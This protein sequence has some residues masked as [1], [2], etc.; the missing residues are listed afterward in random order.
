MKR[1]MLIDLDAVKDKGYISTLRI[2]LNEN[3]L[4]QFTKIVEVK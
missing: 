3:N 1:Y 2:V 4:L